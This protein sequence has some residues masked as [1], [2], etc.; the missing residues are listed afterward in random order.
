MRGAARPC[1]CHV[2]PGKD[3]AIACCGRSNVHAHDV[4]PIVRSHWPDYSY[5]GA[6]GLVAIPVYSCV[7]VAAID[8]PTW[9]IMIAVSLASASG[10][11]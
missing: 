4:P 7:A 10:A 3:E 2:V 8:V 11:W 6:G 5:V 9:M 1:E